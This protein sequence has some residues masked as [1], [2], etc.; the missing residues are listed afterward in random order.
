MKKEILLILIL[1]SLLSNFNFV[2]A[3]D[4]LEINFFYGETCSNC[5]AEKGFLDEL[6]KEYPEIKVNSFAVS[7]NIDLLIQFYQDYD[8]PKELYGLVPITFIENKFFLGFSQE[9]SRRIES[10][11]IEMI[12]DGTDEPC[13]SE[14]PTEELLEDVSTPFDWEKTISLPFIGEIDP[15]KYSLPALAVILG[16]FDGFNVCSLGALVLILG[17][18]LSL[19]SRMKILFFGGIF[20]L[21]TAIIYG[22]LI[23]L[24]YKL[25]EFLSSYSRAMQIL[26]GLLGLGGGIY[27]LWQFIKFRKQGPVCETA[28]AG[29]IVSRF[30]SKIQEAF[31][32][33]GN[34]LGVV[35]ALLLFAGIITIV[36][37]PCSAF[38]P[39]SFA[40]ILAEADLPTFLYGS[41][42]AL[43]VL[44][45]MLDEILVFLIATWKMTIWLASPKFVTWITLIESIFLFLLGAYYLVGFAAL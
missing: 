26:I 40:G 9:I 17:L 32:K 33:P 23:V 7:K 18:V 13:D 25:F 42:V 10:C 45:Y 28:T 22:F 14:E 37:F 4:K 21:T 31:K 29:G 2:F 12:E 41:Y 24:W 16:F 27:F 11:I 30:S 5:A 20:I 15:A 35:G 44:F 43:F 3:Q 38:V 8:V 34:F 39:V 19:R 1:V 36:E 6:T